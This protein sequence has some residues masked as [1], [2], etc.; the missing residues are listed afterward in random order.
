MVRISPATAALLTAASFATSVS[1][2]HMEYKVTNRTLL[3]PIF[4]FSVF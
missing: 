4:I 1:H 3:A 2:A